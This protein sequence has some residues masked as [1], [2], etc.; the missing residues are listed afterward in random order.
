MPVV[1]VVQGILSLKSVKDLSISKALTR[2]SGQQ[3][4]DIDNIK[5]LEMNRERSLRAFWDTPPVGA[6]SEE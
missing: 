2:L 5:A 6:A 1:L 3:A 4:V